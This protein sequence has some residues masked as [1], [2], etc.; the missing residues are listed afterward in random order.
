MRLA[1]I[2]GTAALGG[3]AG[4]TM[5]EAGRWTLALALIAAIY[6]YVVSKVME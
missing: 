1:I 5:S 6:A 4:A 3:Y 2:L